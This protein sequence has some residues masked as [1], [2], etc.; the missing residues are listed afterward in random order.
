[1]R[2]RISL[3]NNG[4]ALVEGYTDYN[5]NN[6]QT[7]NKIPVTISTFDGSNLIP[8][9]GVPK[10]T[11]AFALQQYCIK[12]SY[13][14]AYNGTEINTEMVT[15]VLSRGCRFLDFEVYWAPVTTKPNSSP[16]PVIAMSNDASIPSTNCISINDVFNTIMLNAF[17]EP[18]P[19]YGDPLFIQLRPKCPATDDTSKINQMKLYDSI[20]SSIVSSLEKLVTSTITQFTKIT[21]IMGRIVIVLDSTTSPEY[22]NSDLANYVNINTMSTSLYMYNRTN[23]IPT[24]LKN[25]TILQTPD[26]SRHGSLP[27]DINKIVINPDGYTCNVS[28]LVQVVPATT[29]YGLYNAMK[30]NMDSLNYTLLGA[31][32]TPMLF[33]SND[34]SLQEYEKMFNQNGTISNTSGRAFIPLSNVISYVN[35]N[36]NPRTKY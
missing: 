18:S 24:G 22:I 32:I 16:C 3:L 25:Q 23:F 29:N 2:H 12:S 20:A 26:P 6:L 4:I 19:N 5:I 30:E 9:N 13:N 31:Q 27:R 34:A 15:Y 11:A 7:A 1:M 28:T 33:W 35:I 8:K 21:D 10:G 17:T 14:T 36:A